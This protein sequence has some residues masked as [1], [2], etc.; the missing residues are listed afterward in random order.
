MLYFDS[1][2]P[3]PNPRR[4]RIFA[5]EKGIDLP[6]KDIDIRKR[7]QKSEEYMRLNPRGQTPAL[8]TDDGDVITESI[9]IMRYLEA[10]NPEPALFGTTPLEIGKV[11]MWNRQ[12]ELNLMVAVGQ[13]WVHTHEFTSALPGR[14]S[15]WG[16][17]NKPRVASAFKYFDSMLEGR[18]FL[19]TDNYSVADIT[20]LTTMDFAKFI[21]SPA[22]DECSHL[23][24]WHE[25]VSSRDSSRA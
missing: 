23:A 10:L 11:E 9:A 25:R 24:A 18:E 12:V 7:E 8:Q 1:A 14:N 2:Y 17:A 13:V 22:P 5:T 15:E 3:A 19:A 21:G 20:L 16:E 4:V 6:T